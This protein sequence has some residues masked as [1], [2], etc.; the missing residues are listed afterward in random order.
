MQVQALRFT[1]RFSGQG[2]GAPE[3]T[4]ADPSGKTGP[5]DDSFGVGTRGGG[6]TAAGLKPGATFQSETPPRRPAAARYW[7]V[8][9]VPHPSISRV[10]SQ[11]TSWRPVLQG[12]RRT[13]YRQAAGLCFGIGMRFNSR[14]D[15]GEFRP[16]AESF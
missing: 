7:R 10:R 9:W 11:K 8:L 16:A 5:R 13:A 14:V 3:K 12:L 2:G 6:E 15:L 1:S 4:K